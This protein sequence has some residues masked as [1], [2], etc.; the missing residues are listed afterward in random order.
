MDSD[1][2][3]IT[4][5]TQGI[6]V[7][8]DV[9]PY[10]SSPASSPQTQKSLYDNGGWIGGIGTWSY[11]SADSPTFVISINAD[12]TGFIGV[13]MRLKLTQ[14]TVKY[15]IV[16]A[17]GAFSAGATLITV[18]GGTD[19]TLAN[20][21]ITLP[22]WSQVK[23]PLGFP[24]SPAKWTVSA[25][26]TSNASKATPTANTWYGGTGLSATGI[27]IDAPIGA[28]I[29][30]I[31]GLIEIVTPATAAAYGPRM[32]LSTANNSESDAT[33]TSQFLNQQPATA[34]T[35]RNMYI[36]QSPKPIIVAS[37]TTYYMNIFTGQASVTSI[38]IRGDVATTSIDLLCAYL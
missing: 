28:W 25:T 20:A 16:T 35:F 15:F 12:V 26:N 10:V 7:A 18:Y 38:S 36:P 5:L 6:P 19:Y 17:V 3:K 23:A 4:E 8:N 14:T 21:A 29:P 2:K 34:G 32:T 1:D 37:K 30:S 33:W 31:K 11:S 9:L 13:G 27:S 22:Y 24:M